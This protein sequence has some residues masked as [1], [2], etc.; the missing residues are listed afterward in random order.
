M[1]NSEFDTISKDAVKM[2]TIKHV[3]L[4]NWWM[5]QKTMYCMPYK[6][7]KFCTHFSKAFTYKAQTN[8]AF[9][10]KNWSHMNSTVF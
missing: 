6:P 5:N 8:F 9:Q 3:G 2:A 4:R 10:V 1:K 7:S